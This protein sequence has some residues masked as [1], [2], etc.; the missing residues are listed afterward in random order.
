MRMLVGC[1]LVVALVGCASEDYSKNMRAATVQASAT[2]AA[3]AVLD[4]IPA[5]KYEATKLQFVEVMAEVSKFLDTGKIGDL[6]FDAAK[7]A[8]I[9]FMKEKGWDQ[10]VPAVEGIM[11]IIAAQK[12]P[13]EKIGADNIEIIKLGL[14]AGSVSAATSKAEWRRPAAKDGSAGVL[15][16]NKIKVYRE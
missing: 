4:E 7:N 11:D 16:P 2:V 5:D 12:V 3:K 6:P 14:D 1:L 8:V 13:V 9:A 15:P 10:Y